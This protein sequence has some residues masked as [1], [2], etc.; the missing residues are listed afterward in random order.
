MIAVAVFLQFILD[1]AVP[2]AM[3]GLSNSFSLHMR[4][5]ALWE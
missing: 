5:S 3:H 1:I 2:C 4:V